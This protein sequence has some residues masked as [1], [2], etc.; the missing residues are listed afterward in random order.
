MKK[1]K[2]HIKYAD[3]GL[4]NYFPEDNHIEINKKLKYN[5]PL[6][7]YI[8]KHELGHKKEFDLSH[9]FKIDWKVIPSL[10]LFFFKT[11]STWR[12]FLPIQIRKKQVVYDLNMI[13]LWTFSIILI[14]I[15]IRIL[16]RIF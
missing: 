15:L 6:R 12:D 9:E 8:I 4:A 14:Y 7:D 3:Y 13:I 2:F 1:K 11:P 5:K 10:L 16:L